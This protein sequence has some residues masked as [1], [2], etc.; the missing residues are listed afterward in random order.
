MSKLNHSTSA[1][2][3]PFQSRTV[4]TENVQTVDARELHAFLEVGT[5]YYDWI[6]RRIVEFGF[7]QGID[8]VELKNEFGI[9]KTTQHYVTFDMAKELAQAL[10]TSTGIP[11]DVLI[12][13]IHTGLNELRGTWVHP[14]IVVHLAQWCSPW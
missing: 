8:Y 4:G 10:Q 6:T 13:S 11:V 2:L 9:I 14:L 7:L 5:H 1:Q 3:I 12:T